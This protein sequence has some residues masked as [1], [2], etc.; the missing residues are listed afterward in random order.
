M[1]PHDPFALSHASIKCHLASS[2]NAVTVCSMASPSSSCFSPRPHFPESNTLDSLSGPNSVE[3]PTRTK[4]CRKGS[5]K[6]PGRQEKS[7]KSLH[8]TALSCDTQK[9]CLR[10]F[11]F[12]KLI[13]L[14]LRT[15]FFIGHKPKD[16]SPKVG[17]SGSQGSCEATLGS[18]LMALPWAGNQQKAISETITAQNTL[19][20]N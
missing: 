16:T 8:K 9:H 19:C 13:I 12:Q 10:D 11:F 2:S 18:E 4:W 20:C 1:R 3:S 5:P 14:M 17:C 7:K 6:G 15:Y